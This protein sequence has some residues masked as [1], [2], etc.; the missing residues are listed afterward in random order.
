MAEDSGIAIKELRVDG[1]PTRNSYLMQFQ[2]DIASVPVFVPREEE[3]SGM[4]AAY[5]AGLGMGIYHME[6]LFSGREG[7]FYGPEMD[8]G[9]RELKY[10]GWKEAVKKVL[11]QPIIHL[12][13]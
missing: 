12:T 7:L 9:T 2:S 1:G 6:E 13:A 5:G 11:Y 10:K 4:G 8:E 3:L